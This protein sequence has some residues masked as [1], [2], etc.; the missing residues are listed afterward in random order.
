MAWILKNKKGDVETLTSKYDI[1]ETMA[2]ILINRD[3]TPENAEMYLRG[4]LQDLYDGM[5]MTDMEKA[6][7]VLKD[8]I[9]EG[10]KIR[11]I[12]DYDVD[13]VCSSYVLY[14]GLTSLGAACDARIP[15]RIVDGYGLNERLI[16]E[17]AEDH[18]DLILT[19]DNG[20]S[21]Y[22]EIELANSLGIKV[23]VTDHHEI[24]KNEDGSEILPPA[25]AVVDPHRKG[26]E[27]PFPEICGAV[28][29]WKLMT[30]MGISKEVFEDTLE[31]AAFATVCDVMPLRDENRIIVRE[32]VAH[33]QHTE[34]VGL[35]ALTDASGIQRENLSVYHLGFVL[36]P[37]LNATGRLETAMTGLK[38][39][40]S[41]DRD[42]AAKLALEL[43][44]LN[45]ER[46]NM[47]EMGVKR[48]CELIES[49]DTMDKVLVV[50]LPDCHESVAGII[51]GRI[52]ERYHRPS[53]VLTDGET[54]LK[55]SGRSIEA[56]DMYSAM[57]ACKELF[58]KF[59]GHKMAAGL[60]LPKENLESF[61]T[62]LNDH[63]E[64]TEAD[65]EEKISIDAAFPLEA[66]SEDLIEE[67]KLL[68]PFGVAN[69]KPVF[70]QSRIYVN[71]IKIMGKN[72][73]VAKFRAQVSKEKF[74]EVIYFGNIEAL[75]EDIKSAYENGEKVFGYGGIN[76]VGLPLQICYYPEI[77]EFRGVRTIQPVITAYKIP[78]N[79]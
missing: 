20:I 62:F 66:V 69:P 35:R 46:K 33:M 37:T 51:A 67:C 22:A 65:F 26:D 76:G 14:K 15:H 74:M 13:G 1:S 30:A 45:E 68:E 63:A 57:T 54:G 49:T 11:I 9:E 34:N 61:R 5:L 12:G 24:P 32:G 42:E 25:L 27:Y 36:G 64:L 40:C 29:A 16:R 50:Y 58:S 78:E 19:C 31:A 44:D 59:G 4:T 77:N 73:N 79:K 71:E 6:V 41:T 53:F 75:E 17:A 72:R 7:S 60:S 3:I 23:V 43:R 38:L 70:A 39:L 2:K 56:Y 21:A 10:E 8:S 48:A 52:K 18:V 55:G 28:V 47:T